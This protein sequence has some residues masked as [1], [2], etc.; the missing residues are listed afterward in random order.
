MDKKIHLTK[1]KKGLLIVLPLLLFSSAALFASVLCFPS[2][3]AG[4]VAAILFRSQRTGEKR[5]G[6]FFALS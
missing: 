6:H 2:S 4:N 5:N 3:S 1:E